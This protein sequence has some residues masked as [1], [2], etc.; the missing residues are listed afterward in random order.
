MATAAK[1]RHVIIVII[2]AS[3][4]NHHFTG[5]EILENRAEHPPG[6]W[7]PSLKTN[8]TPCSFARGDGVESSPLGPVCC[9]QETVSSDLFSLALGSERCFGRD[10]RSQCGALVNLATKKDDLLL[11]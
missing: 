11:R 5:Q 8:I 9:S 7:L 1:K 10:V 2:V 6:G 3:A 4:F